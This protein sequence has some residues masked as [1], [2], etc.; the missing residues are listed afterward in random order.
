MKNWIRGTTISSSD[1]VAAKGSRWAAAAVSAFARSRQSPD[2]RPQSPVCRRTIQRKISWTAA[3]VTDSTFWGNVDGQLL[4]LLVKC[5]RTQ[6]CFS[7]FRARWLLPQV[8]EYF[9][10]RQGTS[11]SFCQKRIKAVKLLRMCPSWSWAWAWAWDVNCHL[12]PK[13]SFNQLA[14]SQIP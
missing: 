13:T 5:W 12:I 7:S 4:E 11:S 2:H 1:S 14:C 6:F 8:R 3:V 9:Y 10:T